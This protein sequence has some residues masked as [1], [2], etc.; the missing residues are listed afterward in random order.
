[1]TTRIIPFLVGVSYKH[2]LQLLLGVG[3]IQYILVYACTINNTNF[4]PGQCQKPQKVQKVNDDRYD[5]M[6]VIGISID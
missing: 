3:H 2:V 5:I 1:M 6:I 4:Q